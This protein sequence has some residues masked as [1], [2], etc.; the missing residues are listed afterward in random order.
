MMKLETY[1]DAILEQ[2]Q[3]GTPLTKICKLKDMPCL[4]T[5][6]KWARE[7][8][9]FAADMQEARR[10]GA[11]T[12]LDKCLEILEQ[13]DIPPNQLGF[14][15]EQLHHYRFLASKL[16]SVYGDKSEVKQTGDSTIK[17]IWE[18]DIP[19]SE[20][21]THSLAHGGGVQKQL[22]NPVEQDKPVIEA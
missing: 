5:V 15:R 7:N 13:K 16:I 2:L 17:I 1:S 18:S 20:R 19:S 22:D 3:L 21:Q 9:E 11:A 10:T 4:T 12:W 8:K 14:V 6:Y